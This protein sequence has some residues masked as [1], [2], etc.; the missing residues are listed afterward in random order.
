MK[1]N[2][3]PNEYQDEL[4][5]N[6]TVK[7]ETSFKGESIKVKGSG[8]LYKTDSDYDYILTALHCVYGKRNGVKYPKESDVE[9]IKIYRQDEEGTFNESQLEKENIIPIYEYDIAIIITTFKSSDL[10][11][12]VLDDGIKYNDILHSY[13]YP[14]FKNGDPHNFSFKK[15]TSPSNT[16]DLIVECLTPLSGEG[17]K[18]KVSGYSGSGLFKNNHSILVGLI[19][20]VDDE[21]LT[22]NSFKATKI[23]P[24]VLNLYIEKHDKM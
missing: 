1:E 21:D 24:K 8:V 4:L 14:S 12:I 23:S 10:K 2:Y 13:G 20:Q 11:K 15:K 19:S 9:N 3:Q 17:V 18:S 5:K 16:K 7:L 22:A 6:V